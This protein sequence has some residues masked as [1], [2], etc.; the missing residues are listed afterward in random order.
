MTAHHA[1]KMNH[2]RELMP[3]TVSKDRRQE[4]CNIFGSLTLRD[5]PRELTRTLAV[6]N[7]EATRAVETPVYT[8]SLQQRWS[9]S[10]SNDRQIQAEEIAYQIHDGLIIYWNGNKFIINRPCELLKARFKMHNTVLRPQN[11][12]QN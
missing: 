8:R 4:G 12:S 1:A 9:I 10:H 5:S 3:S 6:I 7:T 11:T 2:R